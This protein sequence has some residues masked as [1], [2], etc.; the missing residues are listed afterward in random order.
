MAALFFSK[1]GSE[2]GPCEPVCKHTDCKANRDLAAAVCPVC[3]EQIGYETPFYNMTEEQINQ[4]YE[5]RLTISL[6]DTAV[7]RMGKGILLHTL[8]VS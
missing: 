4:H 8:C 5:D 6:T 1:P 2:F 3:A 7:G